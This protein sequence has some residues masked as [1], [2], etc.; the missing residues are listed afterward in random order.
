MALPEFV[1]RR[2]ER[3]YYRRAF[4]Q[5]LWPITRTTAFARSLRTADPKEAL[6]AR[7]EAERLYHAKVDEARAELARRSQS[8]PLTTAD[9]I[10]LAQDWFREA[11]DEWAP[12]PSDA[13]ELL[14]ARDLESLAE[15]EA[16]EALSLGHDNER[17]LGG[18]NFIPSLAERLRKLEGLESSPEA[19]AVFQKLLR[20]A[21]IAMHQVRG[22]RLM[23]DYGTRP[24]DPLFASA[25]GAPEG[26]PAGQPPANPNEPAGRTVEDLETAFKAARLPSL[27]PASATAY[28]PV[29]RLLR[30]IVGDGT[31]LASLTHDD[32]Q[33]L[34]DAIQSIPTNAQKTAALRG[35]SLPEQIAEAKRL[36]LPTLSPKTMNDRYLAG[37]GSLFRFA[38]QRGWMSVNPMEGFRARDEV[39][40]ADRREPFG[41]ARLKVL[42]GSRPWTPADKSGGSQSG[43]PPTSRAAGS[44]SAIGGRFWPCTT[45]CGLAR[46]RG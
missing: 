20:R 4:P 34:F 11:V 13:E 43:R 45:A 23:G 7:P 19:D 33:R 17:T 28:A 14:E 15:I 24:D 30:E 25:L 42:F 38:R 8:R 41:A 26:A 40:P 2:G 32:G 10:R 6:R 35:L 22:V 36:G 46:S 16:R 1:T 21:E 18:R 44:R 31:A 3:L 27:S 12:Q 5:E 37:L 39:A 29:F 9:A